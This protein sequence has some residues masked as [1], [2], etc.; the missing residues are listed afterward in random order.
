M[1]T[2]TLPLSRSIPLEQSSLWLRT[3]RWDLTFITLS[4]VL[5][6]IPYLTWLL[7]N[8]LHANPDDTRNA[9]NLLVAFAVGGPHMYATFTRTL[10]DKDFVAKRPAI[11]K[12]SILIPVVVIALAL[13][14]LELLLTVFFFWASIHVLHQIIFVIEA[15]DK[16]KTSAL[17]LPARAIDYAVVLT[18]LYP[19]AAYRLIISQ[20]MFI[21]QNDLGAVIPDFLKQ[22]F[23]FYLVTAVFA[24]AVVLFVIK[25]VR[26]WRNKTLHVPKALFIAITAATALIVPALGNLDTAFQG[27]NT[28]HSFQYLA[29]TWFINRIRE[30]KGHCT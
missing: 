10:L 15:Y 12:S 27:M 26:E 19:V 25:S 14:N 1:A 8:R 9:V 2:S 20:D 7:L 5:V 13:F 30:E 16:K 24:T 6:P 11:V 17:A 4:V 28:W 29:L 3:R 23:F 18:A 22:P 21:G